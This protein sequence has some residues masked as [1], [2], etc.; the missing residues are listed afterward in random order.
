MLDPRPRV[1]FG[2]WAKSAFGTIMSL[3]YLDYL[4][5]DG[6]EVEYRKHLVLLVYQLQNLVP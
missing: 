5:A 6:I 3:R 1:C 2:S 4:R